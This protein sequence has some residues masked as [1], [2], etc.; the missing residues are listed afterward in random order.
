MWI[1]STSDLSE[2]TR[3]IA[4]PATTHLLIAGEQ[5]ALTDAGSLLFSQ[6]LLGG[7]TSSFE[8]PVTRLIVFLQDGSFSAVSGLVSLRNNF[9]ELVCYGSPKL[10][11]LFASEEYVQNCYSFYSEGAKALELSK[12]YSLTDFTD[13]LKIDVPLEEG[14]E[15]NLGE[16]VHI[17]SIHTPGYREDSVSYLITPDK[18]LASGKALG[19]FHGRNK[20][21]VGYNAGYEK[22]CNSVDVLSDMDFNTVVTSYNGAI[23]G[24]LAEKFTQEVKAEAERINTLLIAQKAEGK[25]KEEL[26]QSLLGEWSALGV[27]PEGSFKKQLEQTAFNMVNALY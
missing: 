14:E 9:D 24:E 11:E 20:T 4:T 21:S 18:V 1:K 2:S 13:S 6:N 10:V 25:L 23:S 12:P 27:S 3:V 19:S 17:K 15:V 5:V 22:F 26:H 16:E 8:E 7:I